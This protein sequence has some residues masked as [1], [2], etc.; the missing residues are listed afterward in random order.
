[1]N[2]SLNIGQRLKTPRRERTNVSVCTN[3][4]ALAVC[5]KRLIWSGNGRREK[6]PFLRAKSADQGCRGRRIAVRLSSYQLPL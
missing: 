5:E 3:A 1:M 2:V 4:P 6:K